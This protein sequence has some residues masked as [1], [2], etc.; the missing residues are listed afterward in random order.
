MRGINTSAGFV[1]DTKRYPTQ[2]DNHGNSNKDKRY[3]NGV[4]A[5]SQTKHAPRTGASYIVVHNL[6]QQWHFRSYA[7]PSFHGHHSQKEFLTC[8]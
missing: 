8:L 1:P 5:R 7:D 3:R 4:T 6:I 2:S